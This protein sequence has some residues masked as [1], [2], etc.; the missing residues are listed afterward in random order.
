M[1][2][3][4]KP[5]EQKPDETPNPHVQYSKWFQ[6]F[7][8]EFNRPFAPLQSYHDNL[9]FPQQ[10]TEIATNALAQRH[11]LHYPSISR[12]VL[13]DCCTRLVYFN[14][15]SRVYIL[16]AKVVKILRERADRSAARKSTSRGKGVL[17]KHTDLRKVRRGAAPIRNG[18]SGQDSNERSHQSQPQSRTKSLQGAPVR[19]LHPSQS[20]NHANGTQG[21]STSRSSQN[22]SRSHIESSQV[23]R[24]SRSC[25]T[26]P[27][28][29][30]DL[31]RGKSTSRLKQAQHRNHTGKPEVSSINHPQQT[32]FRSDIDRFQGKSTTQPSHP[33][34]DPSAYR[35]GRPSN[36]PS[37]TSVR[38]QHPNQSSDIRRLSERLG[39]SS[40]GS[41]NYE[42]RTGRL[43]RS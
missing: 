33:T 23:S 24:T 2:Q 39:S 4:Y 18:S 40:I 34:K 42:C 32:Q 5:F 11:S 14:D 29:D 26:Q 15:G 9:E 13:Q 27:T 20:R 35:T 38:N 16:T 31:P 17:H 22:S 30:I 37:R 36:P 41:S 7:W 25:Q 12:H 3:P 10:L 43:S 6:D 1:L 28:S 21:R 19:Q 8:A